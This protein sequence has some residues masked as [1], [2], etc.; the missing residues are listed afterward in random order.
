MII[1]KRLCTAI[2]YGNN[3]TKYKEGHVNIDSQERIKYIITIQIEEKKDHPK[4]GIL[5]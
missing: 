3:Q 1:G 5:D 2:P 4:E